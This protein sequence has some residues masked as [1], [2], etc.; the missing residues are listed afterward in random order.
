MSE[1]PPDPRNVFV[2]FGRNEAAQ[3]AMFAFL[4]SIGLNP[5]DWGQ[6]IKATGKAS[7]YVGEILQQGFAMASAAVAI[8]TPDDEAR[9]K[10]EFWQESDGKSEKEFSG[11]PRQNVLFEAGMAIG[12][13][14]DRTVIVELG[15]LRPL[16]DLSGRHVVRMD[17]SKA[18]RNELADRLHTAGCNVNTGGTEWHSAGDFLAAVAAAVAPETSSDD[19]ENSEVE[20]SSP[21]TADEQP[22]RPTPADFV[23]LGEHLW[24]LS[25]PPRTHINNVVNVIRGFLKKL[26]DCKLTSA[27]TAAKPLEGVNLRYELHTNYITNG[28]IDELASLMRPIRSVLEQEAKSAG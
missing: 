27:R 20:I 22:K 1:S 2:I 17:G 3:K 18:K 5:L 23:S 16:S 12:T 28:S 4:R 13:Y 6:L 11:Q 21:T 26:D 24:Y 8:M 10:Q 14:E 7:P 15:Q 25:N 19:G 9:L